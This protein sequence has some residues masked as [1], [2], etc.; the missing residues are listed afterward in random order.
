MLVATYAAYTQNIPPSGSWSVPTGMTQR[1]NIN[2]NAKLLSISND[3]VVKS[4]AGGSG[5][6]AATATPNPIYALTALLALKPGGT[7]VPTTCAAQG[8]N[9]DSL[10]DGCGGTLSCGACT[11]PQ[12][13]GGA[14]AP[15]VCGAAAVDPFGVTKIYPTRSGGRE[16][17]LPPTADQ[18]DAEW[19]PSSGVTKIAADGVFHM[20]N[21]QVRS[22]VASPAGKAWWRNVE[23]TG[24]VRQTGTIAGSTQ[25][26]HWSWYAR[27]E[28]HSHNATAP[29]D[30]NGGVLAPA[31]TAT[32]PGYPYSGTSVRPECLGT[33]YHSGLYANAQVFFEKEISHTAGYVAPA[34]RRGQAPVAG[35]DLSQWTG[36]KFVLRNDPTQTTVTL[37]IWLDAP[38]GSGWRKISAG[39][40]SGGWNA[41]NPPAG[42]QPLDGCD[43]APFNYAVDQKITWAG[44]LATF[45]S[46]SVGYDF[47]WF[48][49]REIDEG[50]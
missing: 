31:G 27:G 30:I 22:S 49:V 10:P 9:C 3:D 28:R 13:C 6:F 50:P 20:E 47:K 19:K 1:V 32:W 43:S 45:R 5:T 35:L 21:V 40:D 18:A 25:A 15:G 34:D 17:Y 38:A 14:G 16:W 11:A 36:Y 33:A 37:E 24:Y 44:P 2:N 26:V 41:G 4:A 23:M 29:A 42:V 8:K 12:T 48:S 46:D 39:T 7:C